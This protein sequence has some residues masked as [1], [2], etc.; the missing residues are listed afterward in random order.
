MDFNGVPGFVRLLT[1]SI[2]LDIIISGGEAMAKK[3]LATSINE[4]ILRQF[5]ATCAL[6]DK[7]MNIVLEELMQEYIGKKQKEKPE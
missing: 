7:K 6:N 1:I 2:Y 5:R 4:E 3:V